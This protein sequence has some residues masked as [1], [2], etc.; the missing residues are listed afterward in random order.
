MQTATRPLTSHTATVDPVDYAHQRASARVSTLW[1]LSLAI[2]LVALIIWWASFQYFANPNQNYGLGFWIPNDRP[3]W[4]PLH[5]PY[6]PIV[7]QHFFGDWFQLY[8][9]IHSGAPYTG[10]VFHT[11]LNPGYLLPAYLTSWLPYPSAGYV[12][13]SLLVVAWLAPAALIF[14]YNRPLSILYLVAATATVPALMAFDLGQP[15]IFV[16]ASALFSYYYLLLT[17][18]LASSMALAISI[19]IKPYMLLFLLVF[20][21]CRVPWAAVISL[22][23]AAIINLIMGAILVGLRVLDPLFWG[24]II[25]ASFSYG[26]GSNLSIWGHGGFLRTDSS[27]YGLISA[28]AHARVAGISSLSR[29][30]GSHYLALSMLLLAAALYWYWRRGR[31]LATG[32]QWLYFTLLIMLIPSYTLGYAWMLLIIPFVGLVLPRA[33]L[34]IP[35]ASQVEDTDSTSGLWVCVLTFLAILPFPTNIHLPGF[36]AQFG[37]N[38]NTVMTPILLTVALGLLLAS[39]GKLRRGAHAHIR[40]RRVVGPVGGGTEAPENALIS[41]EPRLLGWPLA[42]GLCLQAVAIALCYVLSR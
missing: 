14:R 22:V 15:Q 35:W 5:S 41:F 17:R 27:I 6:H 4:L 8:F 24:H 21:A 12:Y 20:L 42:L 36:T 28:I 33:R 10:H 38:G 37:P 29:F 40:A 3:A 11:A 26:S 39:G 34:S 1:L 30:L 32:V 31:K 9:L 25:H 18:P 19:A 2:F 23:V 7:G 13:L 16:F